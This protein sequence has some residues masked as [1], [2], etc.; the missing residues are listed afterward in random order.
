VLGTHPISLA[1]FS[2][3]GAPCVMASCDRPTVVYTR[4]G[5]LLFSVVNIKEVADMA[6][7]HSE[8]FPVSIN[9]LKVCD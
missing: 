7:F 2:N 6:P 1:C 3:A 5:K 8:L 9:V 4:N